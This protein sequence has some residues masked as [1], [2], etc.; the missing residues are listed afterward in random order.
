MKKKW[1][2]IIAVLVALIVIP[3]FKDLIIKVA[4]E[5]GVEAVTGLK[6][7]MR[8]LNVGIFRSAVSIKGLRVFNPRQF[9]DRV[10]VDMPEI[11]VDYD[12]PAIFGG[13]IHLRDLRID[14]KDFVV[15]KNDKGDLNLNSLKVVKAKNEGVK[16]EE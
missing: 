3:V 9:K 2:I 5:K 10:M 15:V 7:S 14:L 11:Y 1:K 6:I 4:V 13:N 8:G 12:L 16:P